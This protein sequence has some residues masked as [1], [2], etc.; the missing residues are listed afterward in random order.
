MLVLGIID[1]SCLLSYFHRKKWK[2]ISEKFLI[3]KKLFATR[4]AKNEA[5]KEAFFWSKVS[6]CY[7]NEKS[8]KTYLLALLARN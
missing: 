7:L 4:E 6:F 5:K 3:L 2:K 1:N 8:Y